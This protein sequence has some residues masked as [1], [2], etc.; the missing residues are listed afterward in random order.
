MHA[1]ILVHGIMGSKL[2]L[3]TEEIWPPSVGEVLSGHYG[4]V[5]K[6]MDV[7]AIPTDILYQYTSFYQVYGPVINDIN[8]IV[9]QQGG[10]RPDFWYDWRIDLAKSA[11]LLA[12]TIAK[13]CSGPNPADQVSIVS[14]SMGGL[15]SRYFWRAENTMRS[16]GSRTSSGSSLSVFRK[17][18]RR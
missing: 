10:M 11:D 18:A 1:I 14:H 7:H 4:R 2:K 15:V 17:S 16:L 9:N 6:L 12:Q 13:A 5:A 3:D 8:A